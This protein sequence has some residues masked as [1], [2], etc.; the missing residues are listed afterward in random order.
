M[1]LSKRNLTVKGQT[2]EC[3]RPTPDLLL[4][5][6]LYFCVL[7]QNKLAKAL[8]DNTAEC[9]DELAFRKG[10]IIAVMD[11]NMADTSGWWLCSLHGRQ[12]LAPANRLQLLP[13]PPGSGA[14]ANNQ[15]RLVGCQ[16]DD[17]C[18]DDDPQNI[19]QIP[20]VPRPS[21]SPLYECM[22]KIYK[23]PST[24]CSSALKHSTESPEANQVRL[25]PLLPFTTWANR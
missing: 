15:R 19:Y 23:V 17:G 22:D 1:L 14:G 24:P 11:R 12:G 21:S 6:I 16:D 9:S 7:S 5:S 13:P 2:V 4:S 8:Y 20:S 10:D 18:D 25:Y 3:T